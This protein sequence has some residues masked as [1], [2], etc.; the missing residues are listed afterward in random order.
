MY[1]HVKYKTLSV[2]SATVYGRGCYF[3]QNSS[4]SVRYSGSEG[5]EN[6]CLFLA[7][8]LTGDFCVG[9]SK[10]KVPPKKPADGNPHRRYD[11]VVDD[12]ND[13]QIFVVFKDSSVYPSYLITFV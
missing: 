1:V 6:K 5:W 9:N 3:A 11:S 12:V 8:V 2:V 13:P 7:K 4:Y 10:M